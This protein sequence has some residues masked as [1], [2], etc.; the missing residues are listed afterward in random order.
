MHR[1]LVDEKKWV[2]EQR[3]L[4]ALNFC[5]L[6]PGPEAQKLATYVGWLLHGVRGGLAAGIL[7]VL[8]GALVM[9]GDQPALR[10]RARHPGD[11]RCAA[12]HQGGGAG[13][14]GRGAD[15]HRAPRAE[16]APAGRAGR[17]SRSSASS[18]STC[19]FRSSS[20][21]RRRSASSPPS[22]TG[23]RATPVPGRWRQAALAHR[24]RARAVVGAGG[25]GRAR[26]GHAA[27]AGRH[28]PVLLQAGGGE[29]RRR[30]RAA[31]LHGAAGGRDPWLDDGGRRWS[32]AWASPRRCPGR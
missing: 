3:Y 21:P 8:P 14:R 23:G 19:R 12:R 28:R 9:L 25:A 15:P 7:F 30:L 20:S 32:T 10:P 17:R 24:G 4:H 29:L 11:R 16:D 13:D 31:R 5:M 2:E 6:L 18:S 22:A 27:R 1:M 26:A